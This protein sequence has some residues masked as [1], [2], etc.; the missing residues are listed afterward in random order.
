MKMKGCRRKSTWMVPMGLVSAVAGLLTGCARSSAEE[1]TYRADV[2]TIDG[3]AAFGELERPPVAFPH[4]QHS[5]A[6]AERDQDCETCH[7]RYQDGRLSQKFFRLADENRETVMD[8]YHLECVACHNDTAA[9]GL[10]SGP[11][12]CGDCH[13]RRPR[14][15]SIR[16]PMGFDRS[17]HHRHVEH[18]G[19]ECEQCHHEYNEE[20]KEIY[21]AKGEET[22]CRY[23][24]L[25]ERQAD[26]SSLSE[27]AHWACVDCHFDL[28]DA[29]PTE[30]QGC[31]DLERQSQIARVENPARL[32][33]GQ[34]DFVL[35][36]SSKGDLATS[37]LPTVPFPHIEHEATL[38]TCRSC[39][40]QSMATCVECHTLAGN[41][42]TQGVTLQQ[43]MHSMTSE[44]SCVGCHNQE[45]AAPTCAGCHALMEQGRLT[46][47]AC[48]V[49]HTGPLPADLAASG[50]SFTSM[51]QYR[52]QPEE[53]RL[54]FSAEDVPETVTI[55]TLSDKYEPA[56]FPHR[57]VVD[58]LMEYIADSK[59][60]THFHGD[61]DVVC[62][63]CHHHSPAGQKPPLCENCHGAPFNETD[64]F[65]PGLFGAYHRQ[66]IGCHESMQIEKPAITDCVG[67]HTLKPI[68]AGS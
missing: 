66:C 43:A 44:H 59:V 68:R 50:E 15:V 37:K 47:H 20:T 5:Q 65:K 33:R 16:Q 64:P 38:D 61:E 4:D 56:V 62:Q 25:P 54:S 41:E 17:L 8:I 11:T 31:H 35:L 48:T 10:K 28:P 22:T 23:C 1:I 52:P 21:Y 53:S 42:D 3:L 57:Q 40:H 14:L 24:H 6:L 46:E 49:C 7:P 29:G 30:C 26:V 32:D 18:M 34:P 67:C 39:H 58:K 60:A 9:L 2:V 13:L 36:H 12:I 27:A 55:G 19:Q 63:G 45:K 51:A